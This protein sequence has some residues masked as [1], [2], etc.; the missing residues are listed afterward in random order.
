MAETIGKLA[1]LLTGKSLAL[2]VQESERGFFLGTSDENG[3]VSR[4]SVEY[5]RKK[6]SAENALQGTPGIDWT[7]CQSY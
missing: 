4:E 7:Q 3:P 2:Q 6:Q 5:W 1:L